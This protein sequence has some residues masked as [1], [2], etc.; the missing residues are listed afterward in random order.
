MFWVV[1]ASILGG[2]LL[3][4]GVPKLGDRDGL[5]MVVKGYRLLP[6]SLERLVAVTLPYVEVA[7]GVLLIA[8]VGGRWSAAAATV[9]FAGFVTGLT[10]NLARGRRDLDCGC[11][12]FSAGHEVPR[13]GWFHAVRA[14]AFMTVA[15]ALA[16]VP[17]PEVAPVARLV[18]VAAGLLILL[19]AVAVA[20]IRAVVHLGRRPVDDYLTAASMNLRASNTVSRYDTAVIDLQQLPRQTGLVR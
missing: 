17:T 5:L 19:A 3:L 18:G 6:A 15:A 7:I 4:A 9:L 14:G 20:Q 1:V 8:G 2:T 13:I 12:A 11:F 16:L 10:V